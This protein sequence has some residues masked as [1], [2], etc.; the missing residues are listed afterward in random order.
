M[1]YLKDWHNLKTGVVHG[2]CARS[3]S[4]LTLF[5]SQKTTN[6]IDQ[7][8]R[9]L[10]LEVIVVRNTTDLIATPGFLAFVNPDYLSD[11]E[12]EEHFV[13]V[14]DMLGPSDCY[15]C[16]VGRFPEI[17]LPKMLAD[18]VCKIDPESSK[19]SFKAV[20]IHAMKLLDGEKD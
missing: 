10:D 15:Y 8:A 6:F 7:I 13:V 20:I 9:G 14:N 17:S 18:S 11:R 2:R 12:W 4:I 16:F 19:E 1:R 3:E 5:I